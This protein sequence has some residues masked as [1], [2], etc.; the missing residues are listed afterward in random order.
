MLSLR[1]LIIVQMSK[2]EKIEPSPQKKAALHE[3]IEHLNSAIQTLK[4]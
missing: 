1:T 4:A 3:E 2:Q